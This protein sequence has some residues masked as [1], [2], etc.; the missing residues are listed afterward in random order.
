MTWTSVGVMRSNKVSLSGICT[1]TN[2]D[3]SRGHY[4][5][6][7]DWSGSES[8]YRRRN[9]MIE[10]QI[11]IPSTTTWQSNPPAEFRLACAAAVMP[12]PKNTGSNTRI[13]G[14]AHHEVFGGFGSDFLIEYVYNEAY[15]TWV[16]FKFLVRHQGFLQSLNENNK[17]TYL[18]QFYGTWAGLSINLEYE[19]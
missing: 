15:P 14:T 17:N 19:V 11:Q 10:A 5:T 7:Y 12:R 6:G 3:V 13:C 9:N 18:G 16:N 2:Y 8:F 1:V 4:S